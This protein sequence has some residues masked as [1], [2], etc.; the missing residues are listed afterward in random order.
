MVM[1]GPPEG[2]A[3]PT[4]M[5]ATSVPPADCVLTVTKLNP[6]SVQANGI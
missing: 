4:R 3:D 1:E 5:V 6:R 2:E